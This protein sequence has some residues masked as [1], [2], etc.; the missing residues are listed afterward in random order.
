M[1]SKLRPSLIYK[2]I[3]TDISEHDEDYD[4]SEWSYSGKQV[5]RG[6]LD[7]SYREH[8]LDVYWL[9]DEKLL[10]TGLAEHDSDD[11]SIF[12]VL[13]YYDNQFGTLLQEDGW[14]KTDKTLWSLMTN[15]AYQDTSEEDIY[16]KCSGKI[17]TLENIMNGFPD[18]YECDE[19]KKKS[20]SLTS[21][22]SM[23]KKIIEFSDPFFIDSSFII[24]NKP[25]NSKL[26]IQPY[27]VSLL[28]H[29]QKVELQSAIPEQELELPP[30]FLQE[31]DRLLE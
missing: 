13:W 25:L 20:F 9:Y 4:A 23:K 1:F 15:E 29:H 28:Q 24:Y 22:K 26:K 5:F 30:E 2:D 8:N 19:C 18:I 21:C 27:G 10:R 16:L 17:I 6:R 14:E 3:S 12:K 31:H 11:H 7:T